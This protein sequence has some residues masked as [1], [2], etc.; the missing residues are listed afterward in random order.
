MKAKLFIFVILLVATTGATCRIGGPTSNDGGIYKSTDRGETWSQKVFVGKE[1]KKTITIGNVDT[2]SLMFEPGKPSTVYLASEANGLYRTTDAGDTWTKTGLNSGR[3]TSLDINPD[4]TNILYATTGKSLYR[5]T[6]SGSKWTSVYTNTLENNSL[7]NVIVDFF[8]T[9][10]IYL[11]DNIG[12]IYKSYDGGNTWQT[13]KSFPKP[14]SI[15]KMNPTDSRK[16]FAA[17]KGGGLQYS[18][19]GGANWVS[20]QAGLKPFKSAENINAITFDPSQS[21][22]VYLGTNYGLLKSTDNGTTWQEIPTLI[23]HNTQP[24][25]TLSIDPSNNQ[26]IYI[27]TDTII[28]RTEDGGK[29]WKTLK[30]IKSTRTITQILINPD[31]TDVL[32]AG[33]LFIKK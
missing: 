22:S 25:R 15:L 32:Y 7:F 30:T 26:R 3:I 10:R 6:D 28:Y 19:D 29:N 23:K 13:I 14:V 27:T 33:L 2:R 21:D 16:L 12:S 4:S 11:T 20:L 5:S 8:D 1:K 18:S 17:I 31:Q 24:I 9:Q